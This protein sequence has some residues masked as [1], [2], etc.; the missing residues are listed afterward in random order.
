MYINIHTHILSK[1]PRHIEFYNVDIRKGDAEFSKGHFRCAGIHPWWI[2]SFSG[3]NLEKLEALLQGREYQCVGE[4]GL[5][6]AFKEV[7]FE[8][9]CNF[10]R[11]QLDFAKKR[12]DPYVIIHCVRAY[13]DILKLVNEVGYEG[14]LIFHD[15]NGNEQITRELIGRGYYF[16]YGSKLFNEQTKG[17]KSFTLIPL[18]KLF[19]E[20]DDSSLKIEEVYLRASKLRGK[21]LDEIKSRIKE[22]F[23]ELSA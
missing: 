4:I 8:T 5:D 12:K 17:F 15:Y 19:F 23:E 16:S 13:N 22:N 10:F 1:D 11:F 18:S 2:Q 3:Y 9:Q 14:V 6:R 21:T 7:D 20:T